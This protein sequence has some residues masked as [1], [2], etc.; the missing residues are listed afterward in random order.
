M[1]TQIKDLTEKT[2]PVDAD[3]AALDDSADSNKSKKFSFLT[4]YNYVMGKLTATPA[5]INSVCDG[6]TA[7]GAEITQIC[8]G[9]VAGGTGVNDIVTTRASQELVYKNLIG[10]RINGSVNI[11]AQGA[12]I[13]TLR[14][15]TGTGRVNEVEQGLEIGNATIT[16][17]TSITVH[18][19]VRLN[20]SSS[21]QIVTIGATSSY[22]S[23][24]IVV[25]D[26]ISTS[27]S[28]KIDR[29]SSDKFYSAGTGYTSITVNSQ[30]SVVLMA[31]GNYVWLVLAY[32][33]VTF[34]A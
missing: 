24:E 13:N 34:V 3:V 28:I 15:T 14:H 30:G 6:N 18:G 10:P 19:F 21:G 4:L 1:A 29:T 12:Q 11:L 23:S 20:P 27:H 26:N 2:E 9:R 22:T 5:E 31:L 32:N 25:L 8:D 7:T 16:A 17:S 33:D